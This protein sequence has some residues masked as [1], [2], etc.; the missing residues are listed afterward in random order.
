MQTNDENEL[1]K[2]R[3]LGEEIL[4]PNGRFALGG[5]IVRGSGGWIAGLGSVEALATSVEEEGIGLSDE[6]F[7]AILVN[8]STHL[9]DWIQNVQEPQYKP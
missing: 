3:A 5:I 6:G 2:I 1:N 7:L 8:R 4:I 9:C